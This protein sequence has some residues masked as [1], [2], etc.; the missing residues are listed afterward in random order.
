[1]KFTI[2]LLSFLSLLIGCTRPRQS[3]GDTLAY[4]SDGSPSIFNPQLISDGVSNNA[5]VDIYNRLLEFEY[6]GSTVIPSLAESWTISDDQHKYTFKLRK[7]VSFHTTEYFTPTRNLNADDVL[8]SVNRQLDKN[9]PYHQ[10]SG[11][12]YIF[13]NAMGMEKIVKSV[14]KIDDYT[15]EFTLSAPNAPFL[16]NMAMNFMAILSKEY[17]DKL[18]AEKKQEHIDQFPVGTG[19]FVFDSYTKDTLIRYHAHPSYW[20]EGLPKVKSLIVSITPDASVRYQKLKAGECHLIIEPPLSDIQAMEND[21]NIKVMSQAA[22][23][24]GYLAINTAKKP[25]DNPLVRKAINHALNKRSYIEAVYLGR[26]VMAKNP[27]PPTIWSYDDTIVDYPYDVNKAKALLAEAGLSNGFETTLWAQP[28]TRP[29]NPD[30]RKLA[31]MMQADLAQVGIRARIVSY[32]WPTYLN[33][34]RNFEHELLQM[35][36]TG[37]NGDPDNFLNYLL[38]CNS[39]G[40]GENNAHWCHQEFNRRVI[41]A[42]RVS[43]MDERTRLYK[44][45]QKIFKEEAPWVPIAHSLIYRAMSARVNNYKV[46]QVGASERLKTVELK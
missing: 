44:E 19:P 30:G 28:V 35:G 31:E 14:R 11:G 36:W 17:A 38:G 32:D 8:F 7:G 5:T 13:F 6:G 2:I 34:S 29:Y 26:A 18:L 10:T 46:H 25:F 15:V 23:N 40:S 33:R 3:G 42:A 39:I 21:E 20:E 4:C 1:M 22:F 24:V 9:H 43:N 12:T 27:L 41:E 37:D 45:A 16:A